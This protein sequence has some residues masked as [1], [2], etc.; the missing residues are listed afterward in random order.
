MPAPGNSFLEEAGYFEPTA[1]SSEDLERSRLY[2]ENAVR[3]KSESAFQDYGAYLSSLQ[4]EAEIQSFSPV[5]IDRIAQLTNKTN[6][7]NL[8]TR[9]YTRSELE[10]LTGRPGGSAHNTP[11]HGRLLGRA[12]ETH[13][14]NAA[15]AGDQIWVAAGLYRPPPGEKIDF[16]LRMH[17]LYVQKVL[18]WRPGSLAYCQIFP[19]HNR[20]LESYRRQSN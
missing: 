13:A 3:Q 17:S 1:L 19:R 18:H 11:I 12:D 16:L 10:E 7:F 4:M 5:Y 8:T 15:L 6:Q 9:R 14:V 2:T 20:S